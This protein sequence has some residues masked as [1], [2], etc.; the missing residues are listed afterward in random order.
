MS[1]GFPVE[2]IFDRNRGDFMW[3]DWPNAV[4]YVAK[5]KPNLLHSLAANGVF[6]EESIADVE[7]LGCFSVDDDKNTAILYDYWPRLIQEEVHEKAEEFANSSNSVWTHRHQV[8]VAAAQR[9]L[10]SKTP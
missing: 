7:P 2:E 10:P 1:V 4:S 9:I 8:V 3:V 6:T 5:Y